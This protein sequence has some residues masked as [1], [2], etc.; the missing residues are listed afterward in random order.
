MVGRFETLKGI[1]KNHL[2]TSFKHD[3]KLFILI[4]I[5]EREGC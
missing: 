3:E 1:Q 4:I 2:T 5:V